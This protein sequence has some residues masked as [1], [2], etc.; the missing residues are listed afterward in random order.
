MPSA[1]ALLSG[2]LD[3]G[4]ALALWIA[5]GDTVPLCLFA[6]YGQRALIRERS[7][8][9][10]LAR[11][12]GLAWREVRLPWLHD[13]ALS[14]GSAL[15]PGGG[16]IPQR[17]LAAPGDPASARAVWVPARNVV[18]IA[19]AAAMAEAAGADAVLTGFNR[20]EAATFP[21]NSR[22]FA[23]AM[24]AVLRLGTRNAVRVESPTLPFDKAEIVQRAATLGLGPGEF[25]SCYEE[26]SEPCGTCES[27]VR[28]RRAWRAL[29]GRS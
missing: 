16:D 29:E 25:W 22:A 24:T 1:V 19:T 27:C 14:A 2:G 4:V 21:D 9:S 6:D 17:S 18:L 23:A 11:R 7:A 8:S 15:V 5:G 26:R 12:F 10:A 20:E 28:S 3:S 13:A